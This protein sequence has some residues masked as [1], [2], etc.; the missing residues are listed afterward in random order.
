MSSEKF[1]GERQE[2][3]PKMGLGR[4]EVCSI[5]EW[6]EYCERDI[7]ILGSGRSQVEEYDI[8]PKQNAADAGYKY[9]LHL[10]RENDEELREI[11]HPAWFAMTPYFDFL[12]TLAKR[13]GIDCVH[14][15]DQYFAF[16]SRN[17]AEEYS[18][19][20]ADAQRNGLVGFEQIEGEEV[21]EPKQ[22]S[23]D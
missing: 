3:I 13:H 10:P 5:N 8:K 2:V 20:V 22:L 14:T 15:D 4:G 11:H 17:D 1:A 18:E 23:N 9:I 16:Q 21:P 19:L 6:L 12:K 7:E